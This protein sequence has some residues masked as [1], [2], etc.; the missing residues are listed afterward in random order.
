MFLCSFWIYYS[1]F[2]VTSLV[3]PIFCS[4]IF[5][6]TCVT[7]SIHVFLWKFLMESQRVLND[8]FKFCLCYSL[9]R[10]GFMYF[11]ALLKSLTDLFLFLSS[12]QG[13]RVANNGSKRKLE[14]KGYYFELYVFSLTC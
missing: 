5:I 6:S 11:C 9:Y 8:N 14:I 7:L 12:S 10:Y 4:V 13:Q 2:I 1:L 3:H